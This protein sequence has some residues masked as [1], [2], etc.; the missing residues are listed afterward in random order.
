MIEP[1]WLTG[2]DLSLPVE[3]K[4]VQTALCMV[5]HPAVAAT[6][7]GS[8]RKRV[9]VTPAVA[10]ELGATHQVE[11]LEGNSFSMKQLPFTG[12][13]VIAEEKFVRFVNY[14]FPINF[15]STRIGAALIPTVTA[16][17]HGESSSVVS[18][19]CDNVS[20]N[21]S[22]FSGDSRSCLALNCI[23]ALMQEAHRKQLHCV[24]SIG[25][26]EG[27]GS[28]VDLLAAPE[29]TGR[30]QYIQLSRH[31]HSNPNVFS[32]LTQVNASTGRRPAELL[33]TAQSEL[34]RMQERCT[35]DWNADQFAII[36]VISPTNSLFAPKLLT[37]LDLKSKDKLQKIVEPA[38]KPNVSFDFDFR[39]LPLLA[40]GAAMSN[41][42]FFLCTSTNFI[43]SSDVSTLLQFA[44]ARRLVTFPNVVC[45]DELEL[46]AEVFRLRRKINE[47]SANQI[48]PSD[49]AELAQ[50]FEKCRS[51]CNRLGDL[52]SN[53]MPGLPE[54]HLETS[55]VPLVNSRL[56]L[57]RSME[58]EI[59]DAK[60]K[61]DNYRDFLL[62]LP[63]TE[64]S[65]GKSLEQ[66]KRTA[67]LERSLDSLK[68]ELRRSK[69]LFARD[70]HLLK[71]E[72][73]TLNKQGKES[74]SQNPFHFAV[75]AFLEDVSI[76]LNEKGNSDSLSRCLTLIEDFQKTLIATANLVFEPEG[77]QNL[78]TSVEWVTLLHKA[79]LDSLRRAL[80]VPVAPAE[81]TSATNRYYEQ[82]VFERFACK[83]ERF[84]LRATAE[85]LLLH[86]D[87]WQAVVGNLGQEVN[88]LTR[89]NPNAFH[90]DV[91]LSATM[92][93][94]SA[95]MSGTA[96][97][98]LHDR[99]STAV[100][101]LQRVG[102]LKKDE[103]RFSVLPLLMA[104]EQARGV[105][106]VLEL[107]VKGVF[108]LQE[109]EPV[110]LQTF[111]SDNYGFELGERTLGP[112]QIESIPPSAVVELSLEDILK[113]PRF[114]SRE[115]ANAGK[116]LKGFFS[117]IEEKWADQ[118]TRTLIK[119]DRVA[120]SVARV[121]KRQKIV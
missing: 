2:Y 81:E 22:L 95:E 83:A 116:G 17:A 46:T 54:E 96:F 73:A 18:L 102:N 59:R 53:R 78:K 112:S 47:I 76:V 56:Q 51:E 64:S 74:T 89:E 119:S 110:E 85:A 80:K 40:L 14:C 27:Q 88:R 43:G 99:R 71:E 1:Q 13:S 20:E 98:Q 105:L 77:E 86:I 21:H 36:Q 7:T 6:E 68:E 121:G 109:T 60:K 87:R 11:S 42:A 16:P 57:L 61:N 106:Q 84:R 35:V 34:S 25:A 92:K 4:R 28:V 32:A 58:T 45:R 48:D 115:H 93:A 50:N 12:S 55:T 8:R 69:H 23:D 9:Q 44:D 29:D 26:V 5:E 79:S 33:R 39:P 82:L 19:R 30:P 70:V 24:I 65:N 41:A 108:D 114:A 37:L 101:A 67:I 113:V 10:R 100:S 49:Y 72:L 38:L 63:V 90:Q 103:N 107:S 91:Q 94:I 111:V 52:L 62:A 75:S 31:S 15:N 104:F 120:A 117:T 118:S 66:E 97:E 3:G